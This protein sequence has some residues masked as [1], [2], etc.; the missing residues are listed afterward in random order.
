MRRNFLSK[1]TLNNWKIN[2]NKMSSFLSNNW[3]FYISN[4]ISRITTPLFFLSNASS[5]SL[6]KLIKYFPIIGNGQNVLTSEMFQKFDLF[7]ISW[8]I[9]IIRILV[10]F[11]CSIAIIY[12][13]HI[14][15]LWLYLYFALFAYLAV[16]F[17]T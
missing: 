1:N 14:L 10:F 11:F 9:T 6:D 7:S 16:F 4:D 15:L 12:I 5:S 8:F 2:H 17:Q 3:R 13:G